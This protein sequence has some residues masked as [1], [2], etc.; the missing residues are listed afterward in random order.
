M[1]PPVSSPP[2]PSLCAGDSVW[3]GALP[4]QVYGVHLRV[5]Q[6]LW[7]RHG[8]HPL[9]P[10]GE[11]SVSHTACTPASLCGQLTDS[12]CVCVCVDVSVCLWDGGRELTREGS[13]VQAPTKAWHL[14]GPTCR[15][16]TPS[17]SSLLWGLNQMKCWESVLSGSPGEPAGSFH[18]AQRY[19]GFHFVEASQRWNTI[20]SCGHQRILWGS[21]S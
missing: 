6:H 2:P 14:W 16:H 5:L 11:W 15:V 10:S 4:G 13:C 20:L 3:A 18:Q 1:P 17:V 7:L 9:H 12:V 19:L 21:F 8:Q